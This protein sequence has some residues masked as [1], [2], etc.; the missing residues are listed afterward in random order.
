[1]ALVKKESSPNA[2]PDS[3]SFNKKKI[4]YFNFKKYVLSFQEQD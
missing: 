1:M 2:N 3:N 4:V